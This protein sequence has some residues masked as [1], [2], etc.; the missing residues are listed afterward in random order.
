[1]PGP[2]SET[3]PSDTQLW[4]IR[5]GETEWS[6]S[7]RHTGRTDVDLTERGVAQ[8]EALR[9]MLVG[10]EPALVLVSPRLRAQRT[11]KL[12]GFPDAQ[13]RPDLAEWDYGDYE[14][15][16]TSQIERSD[17]GWTIWTGRVPGGESVHRVTVRADAVLAE[18]VASLATGPVLL[19]GHGHINRALAARWIRR[20]LTSGGDFALGTAAPCLLG[21]EHSQPVVVRWNLPNPA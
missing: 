20:P 14:G 19:F 11:A 5:H 7:G 17:P 9:G 3:L 16:T 8:A 4:L 21:V 2:Q 15:L 1:M 12:A 18:A 6:A 13:I 10:I